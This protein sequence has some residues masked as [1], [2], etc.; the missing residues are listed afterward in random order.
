MYKIPSNICIVILNC[1]AVRAK[2]KMEILHLLFRKHTTKENASKL[3]SFPSWLRSTLNNK[4]L[5][6]MSR[7]HQCLSFKKLSCMVIFLNFYNHISFFAS[8]ICFK[9]LY[10]NI[11]WYTFDDLVYY[12]IYICIVYITVTAYARRDAI[13]KNAGIACTQD[14][15]MYT[16]AW[17]ELN[18]HQLEVAQG[19]GG[20]PDAAERSIA[21]PQ[22][23]QLGLIMVISKLSL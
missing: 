21:C 14:R 6:K 17:M 18:L 13:C 1:S 5:K 23:H 12:I 2:R 9:K 7:H 16:R 22:L 4:M 8:F 20:Q 10:I 19:G 3:P 11:S 15:C